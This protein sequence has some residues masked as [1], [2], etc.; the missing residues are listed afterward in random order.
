MKMRGAHRNPCSR[1]GLRGQLNQN[2]SNLPGFG[3]SEG[4]TLGAQKSAL[5]SGVTPSLTFPM[6]TQMPL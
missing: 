4:L 1:R 5:C 2:G 6:C 3:E